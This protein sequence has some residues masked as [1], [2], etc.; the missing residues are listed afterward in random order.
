MSWVFNLLHA[1]VFISL[2][3][4]MWI[5]TRSRDDIFGEVRVIAYS[6]YF[7]LALEG[8]D[9]IIYPLHQ[10]NFVDLLIMIF[11]AS[12]LVLTVRNFEKLTQFP[13]HKDV[14]KLKSDKSN[15]RL[16]IQYY[17]IAGN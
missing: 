10:R 8:L 4:L 13:S 9:K 3:V 17:K 6:L 7:I 2:S 1:S 15:L 5:L 11:G 16:E 14:V 12:C